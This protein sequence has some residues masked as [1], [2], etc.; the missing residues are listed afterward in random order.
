MN[1]NMSGKTHNTNG[2][3]LAPIQ[4]SEN[5][6]VYVHISV[7]DEMLTEAELESEIGDETVRDHLLDQIEVKPIFTSGS[8][9]TD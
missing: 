9:R 4:A 8:V 7:P 6:T 5:S 2:S 1:P 3:E